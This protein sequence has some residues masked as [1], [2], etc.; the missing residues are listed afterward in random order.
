MNVGHDG[1]LQGFIHLPQATVRC[2]QIVLKY[3][4][5]FRCLHFNYRTW[6]CVGDQGSFQISLEDLG[7]VGSSMPSARTLSL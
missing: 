7:F 3:S 4:V 2:L 5:A 6:K 1:D